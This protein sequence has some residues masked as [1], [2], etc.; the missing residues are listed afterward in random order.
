[1]PYTQAP[2]PARLEPTLYGLNVEAL[3]W[4]AAFLPE[5]T[6]TRKGE[7]ATLL[8]RA[9]LDRARLR[10]LWASLTTVQQHVIA[11]VVHNTGGR[12]DAELISAKYPRVAAPKSAQVSSYGYFGRDRED[13]RAR[14]FDLFF[15]RSEEG[16][17]FIP[18]DLASLLREFVPRPPDTQLRSHDAPPGAPEGSPASGQAPEVFLSDTERAA[19]HDITAL[20]HLVQDGKAAVSA[21]TR[22]PSL[23]ALRQLRQ[24][25]LVGDYF[26]DD[27]ERAEDAIRPLALFMLAQ[28]ARWAAPAKSS[29]G[30]LELTKQGKAL[31]AA[32]LQAE[33]IREA[34]DR[35]VNSDLL[36][37]LS[38]IRAIRGQQSKGTRLT[39]PAER[40]ERLAAAL[41]DCPP[42]RWVQLDDF[43]RH[44]RATG[45][46]PA[47][48]RNSATTLY[49]GAYPEY[50]WL[51][52]NNV[53]YWDIVVGSYLRAVLWE[54]AAT[55]GMVE[56]AYTYPEETPHNFGDAYGLD[57]YEYLSR[58]DG[59]LALRL[60]SL[61]AYVLGLADT[62]APPAAVETGGP[63][64]KVLPNLDVVITDAAAITP[65]DRAFLERVAAEQ[66]QDVYR[67]SRELLLEAADSGLDLQ[68][69]KGFLAA[70]SGQP[71]EQLPQIVRVFFEDLERRLGALRQAGRMLVIES[72][73]PYL[74][75]EL[76]NNPSLR[77]LVRLGTIAEKTV[78]F[79]PEDH[80]AAARR[81]LK[82]LAYIPRRS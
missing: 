47:V 53:D 27:Y 61:G 2:D 57:E 11:E 31:L 15:Y 10:Q 48:E 38:R 82:K 44:M 43:F 9:L 40:R 35:W 50:G 52:Y 78:L 39:K 3:K 49:I 80:E 6:P 13:Y 68:Q 20:L 79:V 24:R 19:F 58:Y 66:S 56:I 14:A 63:V 12:Y 77:S 72:D 75:T 33:H 1:M 17:L 34:W 36:D 5:K 41:R 67:L 26:A 29:G 32:P 30:K 25:L 16:G 37:E 76:S 62:Y 23:A 22:L 64:L 65:N 51:G 18:N 60:T 21:S 54:Y 81:Q 55:L 73:D 46:S 71:E 45:R 74:L 4:Y 59:L 7:L 70:K 69:I 8:A 42:G 28:A